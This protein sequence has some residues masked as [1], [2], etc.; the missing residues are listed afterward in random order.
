MGTAATAKWK[1]IKSENFKGRNCY[2][3]KN[4]G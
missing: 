2:E 3:K 1:K 4:I